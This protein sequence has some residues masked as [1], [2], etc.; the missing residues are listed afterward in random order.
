MGQSAAKKA[1]SVVGGLDS[2]MT[3]SF[4]IVDAAF[5]TADNYVVRIHR[6]LAEP[7]RRMVLASA[8]TVDTVLSQEG[9]G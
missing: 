7:L 4:Q 5:T 9:G 8:L 1:L 6:P 2:M 3:H